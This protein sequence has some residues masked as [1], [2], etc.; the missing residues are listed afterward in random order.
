VVLN[1]VKLNG[2]TFIVLGRSCPTP[3][4]QTFRPILDYLIFFLDAVTTIFCFNV[5]SMYI[6]HLYVEFDEESNETKIKSI[7]Q[8]Y[9]KL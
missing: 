7:R 3:S 5:R 6:G 2:E 1:D 4:C 8:V 9:E